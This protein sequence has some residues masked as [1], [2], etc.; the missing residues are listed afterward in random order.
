MI[1]KKDNSSESGEVYPRTT[2][3]ESKEDQ[4]PRLNELGKWAEIWGVKEEHMFQIT[5][6][7]QF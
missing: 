5:W 6:P 2:M 1:Y 3:L 4:V 7:K